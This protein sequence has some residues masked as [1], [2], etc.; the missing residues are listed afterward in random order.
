MNAQY[1][2]EYRRKQF[3]KVYQAMQ[4]E[5]RLIEAYLFEEIEFPEVTEAFE[6]FRDFKHELETINKRVS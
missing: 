5:L 3:Q 1:W 6:R 2:R 4:P